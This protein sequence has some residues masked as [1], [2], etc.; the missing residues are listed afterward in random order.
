MPIS[1]ALWM[2]FL[3]GRSLIKAFHF[4]ETC[5]EECHLFVLPLFSLPSAAR[6]G[7]NHH[8]WALFGHPP[9]PPENR[10]LVCHCQGQPSFFLDQKC[11][12]EW[13]ATYIIEL[14][15]KCALTIT[16]PWPRNLGKEALTMEC[17]C[18]SGD[19][20]RGPCKKDLHKLIQTLEPLTQCCSRMQSTST[21]FVGPLAFMLSLDVIY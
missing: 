17:P 5:F 21:L 16:P 19:D 14:I 6:Q 11:V 12:W 10:T 7:P 3:N 15:T 20:E 2:R 13:R 4:Q 9:P 18:L 1:L 8:F